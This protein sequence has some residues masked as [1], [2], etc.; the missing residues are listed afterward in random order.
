[1]A[2][3][4]NIL[5]TI[6]DNASR[7]YKDRVPEATRDNISEVGNPIIEYDVIGNEFLGALVN[8]I[9]LTMVT[10]KTARNPL[11]L[12]KK[13]SVPLG[14]DVQ[15]I[16]VNMAKAEAFD[17]DSTSLLTTY[18][19]D[20]KSAYYRL[21][22]R[23]KYP[24]TISEEMLKTAFTSYDNL[25]K[26]L[27]GIVNSLYSGDNYDEFVL[28]KSL[29]TNAVYDGVVRCETVTAP[30]DEESSKAFVKRLRTISGLFKFP[31]SSF[32]NY[33]TY[34]EEKGLSNPTAVVTWAPVESQ[35][36]LIK[37]EILATVDVEV[38]AAA[39]NM[40]RAD[41]I[42]RVIE[43]DK[44]DDDDKIQAIICDEAFFQVWDNLTRLK[45]F[46]NGDNL[47]RKYILH[48]WETLAVSPFA[49]AV[50][51]LT[52]KIPPATINAD[53]ITVVKDATKAIS[54]T[55]TPDNGVV[56]KS[57]SFESGDTSTATV[58]DAGV[59]TGVAAGTA[60][61]TITST[62]TYPDGITPA[63][64]EITVTVTAS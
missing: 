25:E 50:C 22:R 41:F 21:N 20:V 56:D 47:T 46:E 44:F 23:D 45:V 63:S 51:L 58:S 60:T 29:V 62:A 13:G 36:I 19:P 15:D 37:S 57:V 42:G 10:S 14:Q 43:V 9:A 61:I 12:L 8:R 1:M 54:L 11:A 4:I 5:N 53:D 59:V 6:R 16:F 39:F 49:N 40:S 64:K 33:K 27:T 24:V 17:K 28:M 48:R 3:M 38:L 55:F 2:D 32:N 35:V 31:S 52:S 34:A 18:T 30:R 26:M 7:A